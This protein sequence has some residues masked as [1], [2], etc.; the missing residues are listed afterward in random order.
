VE[1]EQLPMTSEASR[2]T[3]VQHH[4]EVVAHRFGV[5]AKPE[6]STECLPDSLRDLKGNRP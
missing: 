1:L 2:A 5:I 3:P 4:L 6:Q